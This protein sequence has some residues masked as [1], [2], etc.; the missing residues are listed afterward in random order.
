MDPDDPQALLAQR[1]QRL[2]ESQAFAEHTLQQLGE[3]VRLLNQRLAESAQRLARLEGR[4]HALAKPTE[5]D[6]DAD[7]LPEEP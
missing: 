1:L 6:A 4:L 2:E 5:P 3:E 7:H